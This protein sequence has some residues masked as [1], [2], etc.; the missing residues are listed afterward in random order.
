MKLYKNNE[1]LTP[2]KQRKSFSHLT[3]KDAKRIIT[4]ANKK[5][6]QSQIQQE[7]GISK[8]K[9]QRCLS[10]AKNIKRMPNLQKPWKGPHKKTSY[11]IK[12]WEN[13]INFKK[14]TRSLNYAVNAVFVYQNFIDFCKELYEKGI[15]IN[16]R[17]KKVKRSA[18]DF[19]RKYKKAFPEGDFPKKSWIYKMAKSENYPFRINW[20]PS[21]KIKKY[22]HK[23]NYERR[24]PEKYNEIHLRPSK[25][26]LRQEPGNFE[27]DSIIGKKTDKKAL[28][29][30]IDI[31]TGNFYVEIYNRTMQGF[32]KAL[33]SI[34]SINKLK[35]KTLTADN[36]GENNLLHWVVQRSKIYNCR[37]YCSGD[38]GTLENTHRIV[39][40]LI[41]KSESLNDLSSRDVQTI[42]NFVNDYYSEKFNR[43]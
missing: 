41:A 14:Q 33:Q 38:K 27:I 13:N 40:R 5:L 6:K 9:I 15:F 22:N 26:L 20:L 8:G 4:L 2:K 17:I 34:V 29:S 30:L 10:I 18:K 23:S 28:L 37:P 35:I 31:H 43:V 1:L 16:G 12:D 19:I 36:G 25:E 11:S 21:T 39:R 7:T 42:I 3:Y 32:A 24:K